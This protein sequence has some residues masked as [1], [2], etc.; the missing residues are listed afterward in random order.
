MGRARGLLLTVAATFAITAAV[1]SW[2]DPTAL[3]LTLSPA[4]DSLIL[5]RNNNRTPTTSSETVTDGT[6]PSGMPDASPPVVAYT[7]VTTEANPPIVA[8]TPAVTAPL[9]PRDS[10]FDAAMAFETEEE[11]DES[12]PN[13]M[14]T[15]STRSPPDHRPNSAPVAHP[16]V[17]TTPPASS[18]NKSSLA[19]VDTLN[20][21][22]GAVKA[23]D[24]AGMATVLPIVFGSIACVGVLAAAVTI[25]K[26]RST[27]K[28]E[29]TCRPNPD[30]EYSGADLTPDNR[31][32]RT[33]QVGSPPIARKAAVAPATTGAKDLAAST[34]TADYVRTNSSVSSTSPF[35]STRCKVRVSSPNQ[36]FFANRETNMEFQATRTLRGEGN[37]A[38]L[39]SDRARV[40]SSRSTLQSQQ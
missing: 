36:G 9:I 32:L 28:G 40:T 3:S 4:A 23:G 17:T 25:K 29:E 1:D 10:D 22:N 19:P 39:A 20:N 2:T 8:Y 34:A 14:A 12:S 5:T 18:P 37:D 6:I 30:C 7:P 31:A 21:R 24:S 27:E 15:P 11:T 33:A 13:A 35:G 16:N 38:T 26:R